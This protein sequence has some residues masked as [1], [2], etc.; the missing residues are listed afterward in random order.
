MNNI[1][2]NPEKSIAAKLII[3]I[4]LVMIIVTFLFWYAIR[5]KQKQ[6]IMSIAL[7][8]GVS[9][10]DF[11][12][13]STHSH[14]LTRE[15]EEIQDTLENLS[16][17]VGVEKVTIFNHDGS[18]KY[19]SSVEDVGKTIEKTT[20]ACLGCHTKPE[21]SAALLPRI[22]KFSDSLKLTFLCQSLMKHY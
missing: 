17:P 2:R 18:I 10:M 9:F 22:R 5:S 12:K 19:S 8:Y 14:M 20:L 4:G 6:D 16:T 11:A 13:R 3:A 21:E 7:N 1:F 15:R